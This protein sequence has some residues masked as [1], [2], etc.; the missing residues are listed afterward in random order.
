[1][2]KE[3][4]LIDGAIDMAEH[5]GDIIDFLGKEVIEIH[6]IKPLMLNAMEELN[7]EY[8]SRICESCKHCDYHVE[9]EDSYCEKHGEFIFTYMSCNK[10]ESKDD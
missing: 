2:T 6:N 4:L 7:I 1:M 3:E 8:S 10:W 5:N 9:M